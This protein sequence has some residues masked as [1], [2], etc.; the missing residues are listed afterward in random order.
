MTRNS[1]ALRVPRRRPPAVD[2]RRLSACAAV[3]APRRRVSRLRR[4]GPTLAIVALGLF[5]VALLALFGGPDPL[6]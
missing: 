3:T 6:P 5:A 2:L 1:P 4:H